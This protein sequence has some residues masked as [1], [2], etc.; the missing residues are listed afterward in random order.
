MGGFLTVEKGASGM[1]LC[2]S[3]LVEPAV[4]RSGR[5]EVLREEPAIYS[6]HC[7]DA[8]KA[9]AAAAVLCELSGT[10]AK[11]NIGGKTFREL[12]VMLAEA[13]SKL[14]PAKPTT[15]AAEKPRPATSRPIDKPF[16]SGRYEF[17]YR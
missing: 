17:G 11:C 3:E 10:T 1:D 9:K 2:W 16:S 14:E 15:A 12:D 13:K 5:G 8:A 6:K 7:V 4:T